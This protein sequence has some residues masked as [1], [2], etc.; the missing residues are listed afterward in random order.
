MNTIRNKAT[1]E[2]TVQHVMPLSTTH[3][4]LLKV[5]HPI[6]ER[7]V[8]TK[9]LKSSLSKKEFILQTV[10]KYYLMTQSKSLILFR[11]VN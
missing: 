6:F 3:E 4:E 10:V 11:E 9:L 5:L 2:T 1:N 7:N 8:I